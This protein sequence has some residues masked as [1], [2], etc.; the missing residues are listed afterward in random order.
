[1]SCFLLEPGLKL[2]WKNHTIC[3][4][5]SITISYCSEWKKPYKL[6]GF[7]N[8]AS[9]MAQLRIGSNSLPKGSNIFWLSVFFFRDGKRTESEPKTRNF[10]EKINPIIRTRTRVWFFI[11]PISEPISSDAS[12]HLFKNNGNFQYFKIICKLFCGLKLR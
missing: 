4:V 6:C 5:F 12:I 1:M 7:P 9:N 11:N 10:E 3:K 8:K 2:C